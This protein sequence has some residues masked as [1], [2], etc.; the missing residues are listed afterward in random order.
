MNG[1]RLE[2]V[3]VAALSAG[4]ENDCNQG[5]ASAASVAKREIDFMPGA[6]HLHMQSGRTIIDLA[7]AEAR[8]RSKSS[9]ARPSVRPS[10]SHYLS[11]TPA[12][13][14]LAHSGETGRPAQTA[15]ASGDSILP[16]RSTTGNDEQEAR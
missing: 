13:I 14:M 8:R 10:D 3:G 9:G 1:E 15:A 7:A 12:S 5:A 11:T 2:V 4:V 16:S 6:A